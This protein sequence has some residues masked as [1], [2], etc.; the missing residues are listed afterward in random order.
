MSGN[1]GS[2]T[3]GKVIKKVKGNDGK[4]IVR[5]HTNPLIDT[6]EYKFELE[7]GSSTQYTANVIAEN[8][9]S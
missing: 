1:D 6:L 8:I 9:F 4:A 5:H 7:D 2:F 3:K